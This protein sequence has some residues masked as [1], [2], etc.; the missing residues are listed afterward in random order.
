M[1]CGTAGGTASEI[2]EKRVTL[3]LLL[4]SMIHIRIPAKVTHTRIHIIVTHT[5]IYAMVLQNHKHDSKGRLITSRSLL[6][7]L[8]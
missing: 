3:V 7:G 1:A 6:S 2:A 8:H 5:R 4:S